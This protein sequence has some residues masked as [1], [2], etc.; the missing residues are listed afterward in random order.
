MNKT[1][2][3]PCWNVTLLFIVMRILDNLRTSLTGYG[4]DFQY[5]LAVDGVKVGFFTNLDCV[6]A[7]DSPVQCTAISVACESIVF[8]FSTDSVNCY[9]CRCALLNKRAQCLCCCLTGC[10]LL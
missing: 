3:V 5:C 4:S 9:F 10:G 1:C 2:V 8:S 7:I 6:K